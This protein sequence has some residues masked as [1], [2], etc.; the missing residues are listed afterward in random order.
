MPINRHKLRKYLLATRD[1]DAS[2]VDLTEAIEYFQKMDKS[3]RERRKLYGCQCA[4]CQS[5]Y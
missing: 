5:N 4:S 2:K 1:I 3:R